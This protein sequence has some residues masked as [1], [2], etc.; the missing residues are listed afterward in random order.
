RPLGRGAAGGDEV[1]A[2][3]APRALDPRVGLALPDPHLPHR[4]H[5]GPRGDGPRREAL[6]RLA[7]DPD[8]LPELDHPHSVPGPAVAPGLDGHLEVEGLVRRVRL[9]APDVIGNARPADERPRDPDLLRQLARDDADPARPRE[10]E[11]VALE[12]RLILVDPL[13]DEVDG[14]LAAL[15]PPGG[16]IIAGA[17]DLVEAVEQARARERLEQVEQRLAFAEAVKKE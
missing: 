8:R 9:H 1:A 7:H 11:G 10:E 12:H 5:A 6:E 17:A 14:R 2:D 3:L 13:L 4:L 15:G 16:Q